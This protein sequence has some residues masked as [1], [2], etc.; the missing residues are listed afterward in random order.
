MKNDYEYK[1]IILQFRYSKQEVIF[2]RQG[3]PI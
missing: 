2:L 3:N 1:P